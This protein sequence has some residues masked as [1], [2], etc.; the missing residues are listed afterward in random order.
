MKFSIPTTFRTLVS[1]FISLVLASSIALCASAQI[2]RVWLQEQVATAHEASGVPAL[3]VMIIDD[4]RIVAQHT[5]GVNK[6]RRKTKATDQSA[7]HLGS[8]TKAMTAALYA[9]LVQNGEA[10]WGATVPDLFPT[11]ADEIDPA[12][13][14]TTIEDLFDHSAGVGQV[15]V[16]WLNARRKDQREVQEQ[17]HATAAQVFSKPPTGDPGTYEYSNL[18]YILAGAAI[19]NI[20][21]SSWEDALAQGLPG[22]SMA[23]GN[24]GYGAP[25][26]GNP[27][28]HQR[29]FGLLRALKPG[30]PAADNPSA[31]GPAGTVH[32]SLESWAGF[33]RLFMTG[34]EGLSEQS[35]TKLTTVR[36]EHSRYALG[37]SRRTDPILGPILSHSGSNTSWVSRIVI[38][39]DQRI[40]ALI[41]TNQGDKTARHMT[42]KLSATIETELS[43]ALAPKAPRPEGTNTE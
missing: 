2:D 5:I 7:W 29:R 3:S 15:G 23:H 17:R 4:T 9:D 43:S 8:C 19:E 30:S 28:G 34:S 40:A 12:W 42:T 35:Q 41:S 22:K 13:H 38:Y 32:A 20:T 26:T 18:G 31:L 11:L 36:S 37:W 14:Q 16:M 24:W 25:K 21:D 1:L 33:A 39:P 6:R 10:K 27:F